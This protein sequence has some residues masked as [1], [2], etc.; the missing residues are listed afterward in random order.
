MV[1]N[2]RIEFSLDEASR[3]VKPHEKAAKSA[4]DAAVAAGRRPP[5]VPLREYVVSREG[6]AHYIDRLKCYVTDVNG[7]LE[8]EPEPPPRLPS[9]VAAE[10]PKK[11]EPKP[12]GPT[13]WTELAK[14]AKAAEAA[15]SSHKP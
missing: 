11:A 4:H 14:A 9:A 12:S 8:A 5:P 7:G 13:N 6:I 3:A 1:M 10:G 15:R 2:E